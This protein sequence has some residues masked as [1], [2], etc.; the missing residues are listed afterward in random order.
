MILGSSAARTFKGDLAMNVDQAS[1]YPN[2]ILLQ[3][4][5]GLAI[6]AAT[7]TEAAATIRF[8]LAITPPSV[9]AAPP[10][11]VVSGAEITDGT[12]TVAYAAWRN[13]WAATAR[14]NVSAKPDAYVGL[15]NIAFTLPD[16]G[17]LIGST[18][19]PQGDG[20]AAIRVSASG[21]YTISG[22]TPD[23]ETL[24]GGSFVGPNGQIFMFQALYTTTTKG[25]ILSDI[26]GT[27]EVEPMQI[28]ARS[29]VTSN[30]V[31]GTVSLVRP[32]N[33]AAITSAR[34]YRSGYGTTQVLNGVP[35]TTVTAPVSYAVL[36]GLYNPPPSMGTVLLGI[37]PGTNNAE[38][39]FT[40]DGST[41]IPTATNPNVVVSVGTSSRITVP[42]KKLTVP[43]ENLAGTTLSAVAST[44][45]FNGSFVLSDTNPV[46]GQ[47]PNPVTRSTPYQ[48]L[49]IQAR[50]P[51]D[52][53]QIFGTGYFIV[54][55]L[56]QATSGS[57]P[58]TTT[59]DTP[60][61][62]GQVNFLPIVP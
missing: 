38:L 11:V 6:A 50:L 46:P 60:K 10:A 23:G 32:P 26:P 51:N 8:N 35:A 61:L 52:T 5:A 55:T 24:T 31:T 4:P 47:R 19:V 16:S 21:G 41:S 22:R 2:A 53:V 40:L 59:R 45:A 34:L 29:P 33:P 39:E 28:V 49:I 30:N 7:R 18:A 17:G 13:N 25:S 57:T 14:A 62:S 56:P 15:Y 20:Y 44:G 12:N 36:G 1:V 48:G 27:A 3:P 58:A 37:N 9:T 42:R 43:V 54:D